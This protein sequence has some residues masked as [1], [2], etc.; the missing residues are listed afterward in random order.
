MYLFQYRN[1]RLDCSLIGILV[2]NDTHNDLIVI[3]NAI[4][5]YK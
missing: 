5:Q 2:N 4:Y 1:H 3:S